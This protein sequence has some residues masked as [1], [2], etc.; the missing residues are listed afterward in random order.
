M[1]FFCSH[2]FVAIFKAKLHDFAKEF[3]KGMGSWGTAM[4]EH[5]PVQNT[6]QQ[7]EGILMCLQSNIKKHSNTL[8]KKKYLLMFF[9]FFLHYFVPEGT[10]YRLLFVPSS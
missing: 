8:K 7:G 6:I 9:F 4:G 10:K 2:F 1:L 5:V 3:S